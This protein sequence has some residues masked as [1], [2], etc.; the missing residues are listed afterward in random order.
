MFIESSWKV[1]RA[2]QGY[3]VEPPA[4]GDFIGVQWDGN[5]ITSSTCRGKE[6]K[7]P[8]KNKIRYLYTMAEKSKGTTEESRKKKRMFQEIYRSTP[9]RTAGPLHIYRYTQKTQQSEPILVFHDFC[10]P[11]SVLL[12]NHLL[13]EL[14]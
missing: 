12:S 2:S 5:F 11:L 3:A 8:Q 14:E 13:N 1:G 6:R 7:V 4:V 10:S 9:T